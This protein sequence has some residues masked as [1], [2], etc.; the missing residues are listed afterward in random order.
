MK[1]A[2]KKDRTLGAE[3]RDG[4]LQ[5]GNTEQKPVKH[6]TNGEANFPDVSQVIPEDVLDEDSQGPEGSRFA[7]DLGLFERVN[8]WITIVGGNHQVRMVTRGECDPIRIDVATSESGGRGV[9]VVMPSRL[10]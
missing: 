5:V 1:E 6:A 7:I 9:F 4:T 8:K 10:S 2:T 3:Y